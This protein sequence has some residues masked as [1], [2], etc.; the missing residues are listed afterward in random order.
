D[1]AET[2]ALEMAPQ[3][4]QH[5]VGVDADDGAQLAARPGARRNSV[6]RRVGRAAA[7]SERREGRPAIDALGWRETGLAPIAVDL[8]RARIAARLDAGEDAP[9][10]RRELARHPFGD[11]D[12]AGRPDDRGDGMSE[13]DAGIGKQPAPIAGMMAALARLDGEIEI[14]G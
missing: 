10:I 3:G 9:D 2:V 8:R 6:H 4:R 13:L 7:V 11:A 12:L 1:L 5:V 14:H